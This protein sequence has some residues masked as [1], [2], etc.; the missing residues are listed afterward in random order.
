M[1]PPSAIPGIAVT[2]SVKEESFVPE[3]ATVK[4]PVGWFSVLIIVTVCGVI[5]V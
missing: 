1:L 4:F 3:R 2:D 5:S